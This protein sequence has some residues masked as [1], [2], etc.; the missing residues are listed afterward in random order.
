[1]KVW[2]I[3]PL[4]PRNL[5]LEVP[6][7]LPITRY[8]PILVMKR[9]LSQTDFTSSGGSSYR[10]SR[11]VSDSDPDDEPGDSQVGEP[12]RVFFNKLIHTDEMQEKRLTLLES[13]TLS[14]VL[15]KQRA[16]GISNG[17][18]KEH[19]L[20]TTKS[21]GYAQ[22]SIGGRKDFTVNELVAWESLHLDYQRKI[23]VGRLGPDKV[24]AS[25]LCGN[26][27]CIEKG[28]VIW[29]TSQANNDRKGCLAYLQLASGKLVPICQHEPV[30]IRSMEGQTF[31]GIYKRSRDGLWVF[32]I[33]DRW[34][35]VAR[36]AFR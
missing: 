18:C 29:E 17:W 1:M 14:N 32:N 13:A 6:E 36:K 16:N 5:R 31:D 8:T 19:N 10:P 21:E 4:V 3:D 34:E 2:P 7:K 15:D 35:A 9:R 20:A 24:Q 22:V 30:C 33:D 11:N 23:E 28:H 27:K 12:T 26:R 25:H